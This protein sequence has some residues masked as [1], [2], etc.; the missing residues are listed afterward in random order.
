MLVNV[1][2]DDIFW[3][4]EHFVVKLVMI[5][6]HYKPECHAEQLVPS[7]QFQGHSEDLYN[8]NMTISA[9]SSKLLVCLQPN[10]VLKYSTISWSV[11][12]KNWITAF[13]VKVTA[14][15]QNVSECSE[16][17][18]WITEYFVTEL[19][20]VMQHHEPKFHAEKEMFSI[21]KVK[22]TA[23]AYMIQI[24]LFPLYILNCWFLGNQTGSDDMSS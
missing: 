12:W 7:L 9:M 22:V 10:L 11:L 23:K 24:W 2:L 20:M 3:I 8:Q 6:Q 16:N 5:K 13:K 17:I 19:G 21:F 4:T 18:F 15:V 1:C 14:K